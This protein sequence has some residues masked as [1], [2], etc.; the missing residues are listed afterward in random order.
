[1]SRPV[2]TYA[3]RKAL[4]VQLGEDAGREIVAVL[5]RMADAVAALEKRKVEVTPVAP[6]GSLDLMPPLDSPTV[7]E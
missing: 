5:Q 3:T 6:L 1:M 2:V 7:L 4:E